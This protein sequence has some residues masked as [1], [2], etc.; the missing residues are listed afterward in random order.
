MVKP[1]LK[2]G[3]LL[4]PDLSYTIMGVL[5]EVHNKMGYGFLERYYQK[6]IAAELRKNNISF[7]EQVK[8]DLLIDGEILAS[9]IADFIVEEKII[10]ELKQGD[11]FLK[12]NVDQLH[13]YLKMSNLQLGI[14]I[15]FTSRGLLFKRVVNVI[16]Q[17]S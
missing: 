1:D 6:A 17:H 16:K 5:F 3:D 8:L 2:R 14:L 9:G 11:K 15:N 10:I 13:S 4:Y 7:K 12:T